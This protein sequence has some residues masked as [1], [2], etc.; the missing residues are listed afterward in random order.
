MA[1]SAKRRCLSG[2]C[3]FAPL[4]RSSQHAVCFPKLVPPTESSLRL[5]KERVVLR[6]RSR[7][8][9]S[10]PL[11]VSGPALTT[12][13]SPSRQERQPFRPPHTAQ[14]SFR[15]GQDILSLAGLT[16]IAPLDSLWKT[17]IYSVRSTARIGRL[18]CLLG[19][20][21]FALLPPPRS[22]LC[23][24]C[25]WRSARRPRPL[26]QPPHPPSRAGSRSPLTR[27][28]AS[29]LAAPC[30]R[31]P[32]PPT[33]A[34]PRPMGCRSTGSRSCSSAAAR[35]SRHCSSSSPRCTRRAPP[36]IISG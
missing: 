36:A 1:C 21:P 12:M 33:I 32:A 8:C 30:I 2:S 14:K 24:P 25:L 13:S 17:S 26:P 5:D 10:A 28:A 23:L 4:L 31:S 35:R 11:T 9:L 15:L 3:G 34:A 29:H 22:R 27:A 16:V 7:V 19:V 6:H 20:P 18:C